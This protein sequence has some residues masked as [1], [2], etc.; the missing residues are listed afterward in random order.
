M[1]IT[2]IQ[3]KEAKPSDKDYKLSDGD[4]V[5]FP[6]MVGSHN[7]RLVCELKVLVGWLLKCGSEFR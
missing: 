3:V 1:P 6:E 4:L 7:N 2:A 5:L